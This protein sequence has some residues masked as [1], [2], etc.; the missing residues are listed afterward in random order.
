MIGQLNG[1]RSIA[2]EFSSRLH[3]YLPYR[4]ISI[5]VETDDSPHSNSPEKSTSQCNAPN[6]FHGRILFSKEPRALKDDFSVNSYPCSPSIGCISFA[7]IVEMA[8]RPTEYTNSNLGAGISKALLD[9]I[10][11]Y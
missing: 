10:Y 4:Y 2:L 5:S 11:R 6:V 3:G 7:R 1:V 9:H 8:L